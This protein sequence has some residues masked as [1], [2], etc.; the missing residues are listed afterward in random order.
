LAAE[1]EIRNLLARLAQLADAG[2]VDEYLGLLTDDVVW[3]MPASPHLDLPASERRGHAE[4]AAGI[5]ERA[6]AGLQGPGTGTMHV[7]T[8]TSVR[9][10]GEDAATSHSSFLFYGPGPSGPALRSMGRY[11]DTF[12]RT[13]GGWKLSR[14]TVSF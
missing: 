5:R 14:R 12:R 4:I 11:H 8:T 3:A 7:V 6:A 10:D 1:L 9:L 2:Q 13:A